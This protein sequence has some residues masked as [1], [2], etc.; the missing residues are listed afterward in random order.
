MKVKTSVT[1]SAELLEAL[2]ADAGTVSRSA[3]IERA[4]WEYLNSRHRTDRDMAELRRIN[5][6]SASLNSEA[7]DAIGYQIDE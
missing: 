1:L 7:L 2:A 4:T 5:A 6:A 3:L